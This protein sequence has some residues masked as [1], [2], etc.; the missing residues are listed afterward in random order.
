MP[1]TVAILWFSVYNVTVRNSI[2]LFC[3]VLLNLSYRMD[4]PRGY[5]IFF[6]FP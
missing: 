5:L 4:T 1:E 2:Y 6:V 3:F